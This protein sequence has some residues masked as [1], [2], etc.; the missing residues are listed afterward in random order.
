MDDDTDRRT[1]YG[2]AG[3]HRPKPYG[4][5]YRTLSNFWTRTPELLGWAFRNTQRAVN[6]AERYSLGNLSH[7]EGI[8]NDN[9]V[10][11]AREIVEEFNLEVI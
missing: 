10:S 2:K 3:S 4:V 6:Y 9:N 5:E 8:I 1:L 7:V 11:A